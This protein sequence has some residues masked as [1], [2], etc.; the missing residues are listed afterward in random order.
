MQMLESKDDSIKEHL[1][2]QGGEEAILKAEVLTSTKATTL[3]TGLK[4]AW[5]IGA[6]ETATYKVKEPVFTDPTSKT[7]TVAVATMTTA[8]ATSTAAVAT[9]AEAT[10]SPA[11][12]TSILEEAISET[13]VLTC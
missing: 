2:R 7:H 12:A 1:T 11:E 3:L 4:E 10:S 9:S 6:A 8:V 5:T 13:E